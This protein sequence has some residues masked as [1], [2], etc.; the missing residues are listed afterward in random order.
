MSHP[1]E[2]AHDHS[3]DGDASD[4]TLRQAIV[5]FGLLG[6]LQ[7]LTA[8]AGNRIALAVDGAHNLAEAPILGLNRWGRRME[9]KKLSRLMT[10]YI[11][12]LVP[13][14]SAVAAIATVGLFFLLD[15]SHNTDSGVWLAFGLAC[16]S[17]ATN[18]HYA[19]KL[20][21]HAHD[22]GNAVAA[23]L[24]L[25]GDMGASG[26]A[27]VAYLGIA[28]SHGNVWLDPVAAILGVLVVILV[29]IKP[30]T[31]S[32]KEFYRHQGEHNCA[33]SPSHCH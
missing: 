2:H 33:N 14:L 17:V 31:N 30:I 6:S 29:H 13:A 28:V 20:H 23:K 4:K 22:D 26:L 12:P 25:F 10:C 21:S 9:G 19:H 5:V 3:D 11:L 18:W 1:H 27:A 15:A 24:H 16:V 8:L 32:L 7:L